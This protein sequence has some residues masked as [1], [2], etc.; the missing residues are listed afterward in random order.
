MK[1]RILEGTIA[2][3]RRKGARF[4]MDDLANEL[5][6]SK[7]TIYRVF[8]DKASM[9]MELIDFVFDR[10]RIEKQRISEDTSL[11]SDERFR[12]ILSALPEHISEVDLTRIYQLKDRYPEHYKR[13]EEHLE[14]GWELT[15]E[16]MR[17]AVKDGHF[18]PV[19]ENLLKMIYESTLERFLSS[20]ELQKRELP[21]KEA[22]EEV[23]GIL[24][25][26]M[27]A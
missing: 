2:V 24:V 23:S 8:P 22:L 7:K 14:S 12:R 4:T 9:L 5:S 17:Q 18:R 13:I 19:N 11:S 26:G 1:T 16:V 3:F 20:D 27:R 6:M 25:D 21:Y 10:I 15:F